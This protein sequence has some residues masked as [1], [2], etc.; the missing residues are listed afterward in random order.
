MTRTNSL[1]IILI[2]FSLAAVWGAAIYTIMEG[3]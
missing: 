2:A 1:C 3:R